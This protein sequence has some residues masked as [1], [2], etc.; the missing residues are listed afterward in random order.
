MKSVLFSSGFAAPNPKS[1]CRSCP[2][3]ER[4]QWVCHFWGGSLWTF[5][6]AEL[7]HSPIL[8]PSVPWE[9]R[10]GSM[11]LESLLVV[12]AQQI[13]SLTTG[14]CCCRISARVPFCVTGDLGVR[15]N[16]GSHFSFCEMPL[17]FAVD[18]CPL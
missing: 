3:S 13:H 4:G 16:K 9:T 15:K 2:S 10:A 11:H 8:S 18:S 17:F 14:I 5:Q 1:H 7:P 12:T 6:W